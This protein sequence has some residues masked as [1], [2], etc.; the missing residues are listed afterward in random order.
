[1]SVPLETWNAVYD[2]D[3]A[4]WV[5]GEPQ[6]AIVALEQQGRISGRVLDPGTGAG[7]HTILLT[8]LGYDVRGIDVSPSAV[9][10]ARRNAAAQGVPSARFH[11][12]DALNLAAAEALSDDDGGAPVFDT[13]V[14]SA[15]FHVFGEDP[16]AR[17][18]YVRSLHSVCKPGGLVH[19]LALSDREPGIG[20]RISDTLIR[21]SFAD[22]WE[23]EDLQP[24]RYLGR[25]TESVAEQAAELEQ[26]D[27]RV[28]VAAWLARF[29]RQ[30]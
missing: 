12:A 20:P 10:Y 4:P 25:V 17:A 22:G 7:E 14:D 30:P 27:G 28:S 29:R 15:L 2:N 8:R 21:E 11:V 18:A 9:E 24:V 6:P 26:I 5:I 19:V 3:S 13:I 1:M 16:D 23:L